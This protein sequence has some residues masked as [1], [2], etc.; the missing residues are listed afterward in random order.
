MVII[1]FGVS[2]A[3]KSTIGRLLARE[4]GWRFYEADDFHP[5]ANVEKM[6]QGMPLGDKE[7]QPWLE[8]LLKLIEETL[9]SGENA[10]LACSALKK[11]YRSYLRVSAEVKFIYLR[12]SPE[13]VA[14]QLQQRRGHFMD[15]ALLPSQFADLEEPGADEKVSVVDLGP[16]PRALVKEIRKAIGGQGSRH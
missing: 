11:T 1:L 3:G 2:G 9:A 10:V 4:L 15:P 12:G 13:M 7:R 16:N 5:P 14:N 6:R 8:S